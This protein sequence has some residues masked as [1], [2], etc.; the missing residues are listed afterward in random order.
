MQHGVCDRSPLTSL[1][2][3]RQ[4]SMLC[5]SSWGGSME[6]KSKQRSFH[7]RP[8]ILRCQ[9]SFSSLLAFHLHFL[10]RL[11]AQREYFYFQKSVR[12]Q[13]MWLDVSPLQCKTWKCVFVFS[14]CACGCLGVPGKL[15]W[16]SCADAGWKC[17]LWEHW[18]KCLPRA[19]LSVRVCLTGARVTRT[20]R[21]DRMTFRS[22]R[23]WRPEWGW[24][25]TDLC[26][27]WISVFPKQACPV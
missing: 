23:K 1:T 2:T 22:G 16:M 27:Q 20:P 9:I 3:V 10:V 7:S 19:P 8:F 5:K 21:P 14:L 24:I 26:C 13:G 4:K 6:H 12:S 17:V 15:E 11:S 18:A 25:E